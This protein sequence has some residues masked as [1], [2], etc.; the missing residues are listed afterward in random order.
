MKKTNCWEFKQCGREIGG[1]NKELPVCPAATAKGLH[2][3]HGGSLGGRACWVVAGTM[4]EAKPQGTFS[5]KYLNCKL[6]DF[7]QAVKKE[8]GPN[9]QLSAV[10][11]GKMNK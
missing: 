5:Q 4:C 7:Y 2:G 6:C 1:R 3:T 8:E 10:L 11:I 9:F